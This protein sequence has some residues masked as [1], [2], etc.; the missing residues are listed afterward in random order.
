MGCRVRGL[1]NGGCDRGEYR[2]DGGETVLH[3]DV[4]M[5]ITRDEQCLESLEKG[6]C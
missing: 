1:R 4:G 3:F 2:D 6:A 5:V